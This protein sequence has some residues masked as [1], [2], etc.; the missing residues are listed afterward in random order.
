MLQV[1]GRA[2]EL[3]SFVKQGYA[4]GFIEIELK[5]LRG[6]SNLVIRRH[7]KSTGRGSTFTLNGEHATA[8]EVSE[9]VKALNVQVNN[10][11]YFLPM[12]RT[13]PNV[14]IALCQCFLASR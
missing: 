13:V 7:M 14:L 10:L 6:T 11:W 8:K 2:T 9:H 1:L 4:E 12:P 5:G 3:S